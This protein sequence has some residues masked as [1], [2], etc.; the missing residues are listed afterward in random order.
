VAAW[1]RFDVPQLRLTDGPTP[2]RRVPALDAA[3]SSPDVFIKEEQFSSPEVGGTKVRGLEFLLGGAI[4]SGA[5][6]VVTSAVA[7]S[8]Y[9]AALAYHSRQLGLHCV[10]AVHPTAA[11][12]FSCRNALFAH[13]QGCEVVLAA[14]EIPLRSSGV[15]VTGLAESLE[16]RGS[17]TARLPF[18][19]GSPL[20]ALGQVAAAREAAHQLAHEV[21]PNAL[22][23]VV[24]VG[25]GWT[26]AGLLVGFA[27]LPFPVRV[28][29][30]PAAHERPLPRHVI[31]NHVQRLRSFLQQLGGG[32]CDGATAQLSWAPSLAST[33]LAPEDARRWAGIDTDPVYTSDAFA[34]FTEVVRLAP[35]GRAVVFWHTADLRPR[36]ALDAQVRA[37]ELPAAVADVLL[38]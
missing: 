21:A 12:F 38:G 30:V 6:T 34:A 1:E 32:G 3:L 4:A 22:D 33:V 10:A 29:A 24:A 27:G 13:Q 16:R 20:A 2:L 28:V 15:L 31:G 9:L 26:A 36:S 11:T 25:T 37:G 35:P 7:G 14:Q 23:V 5:D 17:R 8:N 19:G 18:G